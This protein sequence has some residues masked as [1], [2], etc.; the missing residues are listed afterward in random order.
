MSMRTS[1]Q[2]GPCNRFEK[3]FIVLENFHKL[4]LDTSIKLISRADAKSLIKR[5][6]VKFQLVFYFFRSFVV[7]ALMSRLLKSDLNKKIIK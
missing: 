2:Q 1:Y 6:C 4:S 3:L 7:V 5:E